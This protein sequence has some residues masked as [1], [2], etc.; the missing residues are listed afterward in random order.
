MVILMKNH[1]SSGPSALGW[2]HTDK[3]TGKMSTFPERRQYDNAGSPGP[4]FLRQQLHA[5][6]VD[7]VSS[8]LAQRPHRLDTS[9]RNR[10]V[11]RGD[12]LQIDHCS[13]NQQLAGDTTFE[14]PWTSMTIVILHSMVIS[15][16]TLH[17]KSVCW[18]LMHQIIMFP[19]RKWPKIWGLLDIHHFWTLI[20]SIKIVMW[21]IS[22][23]KVT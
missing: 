14:K 2:A 15:H 22:S 13:S 4:S 19:N 20:C 23:S 1:R 12:N 10:P 16:T 21:K 7:V 3:K 8:V 17:G 11:R 6:Y 9:C 5:S 18:N